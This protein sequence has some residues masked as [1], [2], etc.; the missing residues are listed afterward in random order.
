M[1]MFLFMAL[2]GFWV[3]FL[4]AGF[5]EWGLA[6]FLEIMPLT[7]SLLLNSMN[8]YLLIT[9]V[10]IALVG[11]YCQLSELLLNRNRSRDVLMM[12]T[13]GIIVLMAFVVSP[14]WSRFLGHVLF[15]VLTA[16]L[17]AATC[18]RVILERTDTFFSSLLFLIGCGV[19][20]VALTWLILF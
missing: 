15:G 1:L 19:G 3:M 10:V 12:G 20:V 2:I 4:L 16:F 11:N 7:L 18:G 5:L 9:G 13:G 8:T 14:E 6:V 17:V